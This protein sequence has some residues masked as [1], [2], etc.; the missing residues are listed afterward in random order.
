MSDLSAWPAL[1]LTAGLGT[2][3]RP[4]SDVRAKAAMPVA[5]TSIIARTLTWLHAAGIRRVII[6]LHHR[7]ESITRV[8]GDGSEW[9]VEVRYSWEKRVLGSAGGPR[10]ALALLDA[11]RFL[12]VN[13][14]TLTDCDLH[15]LVRHHLAR[16]ARVT[17]AVTSG[18]ISR[19]GGVL[20]RP[21]GTVAGFSRGD[22]SRSADAARP[23]L[24]PL[25]A[26][27][28]P[29]GQH[30]RH[31]IGVQAV[32][33]DVFTDLPDDQPTE[34]VG[35]RY[36]ALIAEDPRAI[37]TFESAAEFLDVGTPADY[38]NTVARVAI[39]EGVAFDRG[40]DCVI[41]RS[42]LV[43]DSI[44]W[45]RVEV[46]RHVELIN[47]IVADEVRLPPGARYRN[48]AMVNSPNGLVVRRF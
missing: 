35:A 43:R 48:S 17:M 44:L 36:P 26:P 5:G 10:R 6:N 1:V 7:P 31:F 24:L 20:T 38:Y 41:D 46:A 18:D 45:D 28:A 15:R 39:R 21:D 9:A 29:P 32:N 23:P 47:C 40:A 16:R 11:D 8:V 27:P 33:A 25:L 4:L 13:G 30:A 3:L 12:I 2:R 19:Y 37:A 14:D 22:R 34:T 42:A